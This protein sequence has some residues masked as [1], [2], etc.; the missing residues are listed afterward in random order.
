MRPSTSKFSAGATPPS[1]AAT[2]L[3]EYNSRLAQERKAERDHLAQIV[4]ALANRSYHL[5]GNSYW[6]DWLQYFLNNHPVF[7]LCCSH[8]YHPMTT[9]NRFV[10]LIGSI[11][12]GLAITN[13]VYLWFL[14][15]SDDGV[16]GKFVSIQV[17][18]GKNTTAL[19]TAYATADV[20]VT[21]QQ[22]FL[23]TVGG[24]LHSVFDLSIWFITACA[25]CLPGGKMESCGRWKWM[26]SYFVLITVTIVAAVA[27]LVVLLRASLDAN[28][29]SVTAADLH[30]AG[31]FD[32]KVQLGD[33][34]G[35]DSFRFLISWTVEVALALFV[36]NP[37]IGTILFS[38][39]LGCGK[40]PFL[41]GRPREMLLEEQSCLK[42]ARTE[43]DDNEWGLSP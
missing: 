27:S 28:R 15:Y 4:P 12:S 14:T 30:S 40:L 25:C 43:M 18:L 35:A 29:N 5:P 16:D 42:A 1:I 37:I 39:V 19:N 23:W 2:R 11:C 3:S 38:G 21:N 34:N 31:I 13:F 32:D 26:G 17:D 20:S 9:C 33:N 24:A 41:G 6:R 7:G 36:Y 8:P 22:I 10:V